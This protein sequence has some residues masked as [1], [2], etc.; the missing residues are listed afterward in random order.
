MSEARACPRCGADLP[1]D[2]PE[3][4]CPKCLLGGGLQSSGVT[5]APA[6][7]GQ[8]PPETPTTPYRNGFTAPAPAE[9]ARL[10]PQLEILELLGQGG[11]GAVYKARQPG[12]DRLVALKIL[13]PEAGGA[14]PLPSALP[15]R[16]APWHASTIPT[17]SRC[18]ISAKP[19]A[20][21]VPQAPRQR[22]GDST[23][24]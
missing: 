14:A 21:Q 17:S 19:P 8:R 2:A 7:A 5:S 16:P 4:L 6:D 20:S 22:L 11:M 1:S 18:T 9:L 3:G 15:A 24:S 23:T 10:F 12:L 13:P